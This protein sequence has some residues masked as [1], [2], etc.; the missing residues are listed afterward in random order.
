MKIFIDNTEVDA[1]AGTGVAI[2]LSVASHTRL[3]AS[4]TGYAKTITIPMTQRN[5]AI[6][7]DGEQ[8]NSPQM[9]NRAEHSARIEQDGCIILEGV[10]HL[11]ESRCEADGSGYYRIRI[12]GPAVQWV[13]H[14]AETPLRRLGVDFGETFGA[15]TI[16]QSWTWNKPVKFLPVMRMVFEPENANNNLFEPQKILTFEDY[17]PFLHV[18]SILERIF[19]EAGYTLQSEF[20]NGLLFDTLY[21]SGNYPASDAARLKARMDFRAG[22]F[23]ASAA[24]SPNNLGRVFATPYSNLNSVGNLV[25]TADPN[26]V[27]NGVTVPGVFSVGGCFKMNGSHPEFV[28]PVPVTLGFEYNIHYTTDY[29]MVDRAELRGYDTVY[30]GDGQERR[31]KIANMFED[32]RDEARGQTWY[33]VM[34]FGFQSGTTHRIRYKIITNPAADPKNLKPGEFQQA[35]SGTLF[36][37]YSSVFF[38]TSLPIADL[39]LVQSVNG[40]AFAPYSGDWALYDDY[41]EQRGKVDVELRVQSAPERV[42]PSQPKTFYD[43]YFGGAEPGMFFTLRSTTTVRPVF[44]GALTEGTTVD[45]ATVAGHP[46]SCLDVVNAVKQMFNLYFLTDRM[47]RVVYVEPRA[48][49]YAPEPVVDLTSRI[50]FSQ[51]VVVSELGADAPARLTFGYGGGGDSAMAEWNRANAGQ[52]FGQWSAEVGGASARVGERAYVNAMFSPLLCRTG[53]LN[54]APSAVLLQAGSGSGF[55]E[56]NE[57]NFAPKIVRYLGMRTLPQGETWG[58]PSDG[59]NYP[60]VAFHYAGDANPYSGDDANPL[61]TYAPDVATLFANGLSLCFEDRDGVA[62]IHRFWDGSVEALRRARCV[63]LSLVLH[64]EEIEAFVSPNAL[65]RDFR[66][67]YSLTLDG[68]KSLFRLEEICDYNPS[69]GRAVRCRFVQEV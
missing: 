35:E 22:R 52:T 27:V 69:S 59:A 6:M 28:P 66:A 60:F 5:R 55:D 49:F 18:R 45:F 26:E 51:P 7:G 2:S 12:V 34:L 4:R 10:P 68:E 30:L 9:F 41:V 23:G 21:M 38:A 31:F 13:R 44:A 11:V 56:G 50:D 40:A 36:S 58:W 15:E 29:Y 67:L 42:T 16:R 25:Q 62:G 17:H 57:A 47:T 3:E 37:R 19:A 63:E 32:R 48:E 54:T 14:A 53:A 61:S 24:A 64:P 39:V 43:I 33:R 8:L 65:G 20:I 46:V 1:D